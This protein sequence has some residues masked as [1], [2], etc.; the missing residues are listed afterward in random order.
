VQRLKHRFWMG[1][2]DAEQ[3]AGGAF[4]ASV[5]L[6]P[7]LESAGADADERGELVLAEPQLFAHGFGVRPFQGGAAGGF[8]LAAQDGTT[9]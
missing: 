7:V 8:F 9:L 5:S 3:G 2:S 6:F 4:G 1:L